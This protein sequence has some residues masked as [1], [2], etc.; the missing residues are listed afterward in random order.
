MG[1]RALCLARRSPRHLRCPLSYTAAGDLDLDLD[2]QLVS[3]T[4]A[5]HYRAQGLRRRPHSPPQQR[6]RR[7]V[8]AWVYTLR[9]NLLGIEGAE[10]EVGRDGG[11]EKSAAYVLCLAAGMCDIP[12]ARGHTQESDAKDGR[13]EPVIVR[14]ARP[15]AN[16]LC[17]TLVHDQCVHHDADGC[18]R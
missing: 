16:R 7:L 13:A 14:R 5:Q 6:A 17:A 12:P 1:V 15:F 8:V 2:L 18:V 11:C 10:D 9:L 4:F 3:A